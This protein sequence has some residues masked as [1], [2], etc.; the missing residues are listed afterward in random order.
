MNHYN[1]SKRRSNP[2]YLYGSEESRTLTTK[3]GGIFMEESLAKFCLTLAVV[4]GFVG[5]WKI[6]WDYLTGKADEY[7]K[8]DE[9]I[10]GLFNIHLRSSYAHQFDS[11]CNGQHGETSR[12]SNNFCYKWSFQYHCWNV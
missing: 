12:K 6:A 7:K 2:C 10:C 8:T 11:W 1:E 9:K 4:G 3:E 5:D